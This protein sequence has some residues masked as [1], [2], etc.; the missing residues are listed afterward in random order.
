MKTTRHFRYPYRKRSKG[1]LW[2]LL[3]LVGFGALAALILGRRRWWDALDLDA[4]PARRR[5]SRPAEPAESE[6][7]EETSEE[8]REAYAEAALPQSLGVWIAGPAGNLF[9][10][11]GGEEHTGALPVLF[12][13]SLAGNG[14]QWALQLDHLRRHRRAV[15]IDLRGH[16]DSDP[17]DDG[18]YTIPAFAGDVAAVADELALRR[19]VL[20]GHSLGASVAI[21][22]AGRHPERVAGLL[23]ADPNGDQ[24][25]IP[26]EQM[27]PFLAALRS[28]PLQ[29]LD[30]YFRQLV[31]QGDHD[32]ADWVLEDL[33]LTHEDAVAKSVEGA[34][35]YSP[36]PALERYPGPKLTIVS[37]M[38]SM[39]FSLHSLLPDLPVRYMPGT[40]HWLMM[41]RPEAFNR[42]LDDFLNTLGTLE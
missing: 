33:R 21:E 6:D 18:D 4:R 1:L 31:A 7:A 22:Y 34:M 26:R 24:T 2:L 35:G 40:G 12:V 16:G 28:D 8:S 38:N 42:L 23:L 41:D 11:D 30:S 10:R 3:S 32:A 19:F 15:A 29:E 14:G 20:A 39:P 17:A 25:R 13:H 5:A 36:L 37:D 27:E 9:V